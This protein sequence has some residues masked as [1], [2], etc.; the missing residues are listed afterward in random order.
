MDIARELQR[1]VTPQTVYFR[2]DRKLKYHVQLCAPRLQCPGATNLVNCQ[3]TIIFL[4]TLV[5]R[6]SGRD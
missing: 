3:N 6:P 2:L 5:T 4:I 1:A